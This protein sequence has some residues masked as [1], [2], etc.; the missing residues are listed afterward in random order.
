M[1]FQGTAASAGLALGRAHHI[2]AASLPPIAATI[3]PSFVPSELER[4]N[5]AV[6]NAAA[7]LEQ[8]CSNLLAAE[9][10]E[11]AEIIELQLYL[12]QD[13]E[14]VGKARAQ[15]ERSLYACEAA[16]AEA[17]TEAVQAILQL[18]DPY[19]QERTKDIEDVGRRIIRELEGENG[20]QEAVGAEKALILICDDLLP[21]EAVQLDPQIIAGVAAAAGGANSHFAIIAR[22]IGIPVVMG[23]GRQLLNIRQGELLLLDGTSGRVTVNPG[24]SLM[25]DHTQ[26]RISLA[27]KAHAQRL[28]LDAAATVDKFE[29][30]AMAEPLRKAI[31]SETGTATDRPPLL[32]ANIGSVRE[33]EAAQASCADG[34]GLFRTEFLFMDR[35][36]FP[37][38]EEQFETY[39]A[40]AVALHPGQPII[41]RTMDAGGDK[42]LPSLRMAKEDNPFLGNRGIRISLQR[43][44]LLRTQL[45]AV[46]RAS[47]YGNV[48]LLFPM[49]AA[50]SEWR[51]VKTIV[52]E[53]KIS[54]VEENILFNPGIE[55]GIMIEVPA[56]A[57]MA[58]RFAAEV[59]FFS[60]GTNDL[61]QYTMAASRTSSHNGDL[62]DPLQPAVLRLIHGVIQAA[63]A[64]G[65]PVALCGEM[66]AHPPAIPLLLGMGLD[67]F[68]VSSPAIPAVR[69]LLDEG[70]KRFGAAG[71]QNMAMAAMNMDGAA[72]VRHYM[73]Q[74]FPASR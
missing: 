63:H 53:V 64:Y 31:R 37:T 28:K 61:L 11:E 36:D 44:E 22:S 38:E 9:R 19:F 24:A 51:Q 29:K 57:I 32:M 27:H 68:S 26:H 65:R 54:L 43:Q 35:N 70:L 74:H 41:I 14:L 66:A 3:Q 73:A 42:P 10:S 17:V 47:A 45:R 58:D 56:A 40:V 21:S 30:E 59:D 34:I 23:I 71:L 69:G 8:L 16:V 49:I 48:K 50:L 72:E 46:L 25:E 60:I 6:M 39:R 55:A 67:E 5:K 20:V 2:R 12:L 52:D 4:L 18:D 1:Q 13:P 62:H 15:I 33:A 7:A